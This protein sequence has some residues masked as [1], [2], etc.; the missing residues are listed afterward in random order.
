MLCAIVKNENRYI[1]E[2]IVYHHSLGFD[3]ILLYDNNDIN[4]EK[5]DVSEY[6][7]VSVVDYRGEHIVQPENTK[8]MIFRDGIQEVAYND[9]YWKRCG[10]YD[11]VAFFDVDEF[12]FIDSGMT[13]NGFLSQD[14]FDGVDAIQINWETYGDN[15]NVLYEDKPVLERFKTPTVRQLPYIK[16]IV[17][18]GNNGYVSL[19]IH[20]AE[21]RNGKFVYPNGKNTRPLHMQDIDYEGARVKHFYTKTIDEWVDRKCGKTNADGRDTLNVPMRRLNEFFSYNNPTKE[22]T[23]VIKRKLGIEI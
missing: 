1:D 17:R 14:K 23:D 9:C 4:G 15:D 10:G 18:T 19:R 8:M 21:I 22:K 6:P 3:G 7:Y 12:L 13:V 2:W 16:S 11:W 5:L 20:S